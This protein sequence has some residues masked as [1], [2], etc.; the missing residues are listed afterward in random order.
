[1]RF[2]VWPQDIVARMKDFHTCR[3]CSVKL[4][5]DCDNASPRLWSVLRWWWAPAQSW[6]V[7]GWLL[8]VRKLRAGRSSS[9]ELVAG[10]DGQTDAI[11]TVGTALLL[12][13]EGAHSHLRGARVRPIQRPEPGGQLKWRLVP[14]WRRHFKNH[15]LLLNIGLCLCLQQLFWAYCMSLV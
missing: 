11:P 10:T 9:V 14:A 7:V 3:K 6:S 15:K 12:L 4:F 5:A 1:M 8:V 2:V 13:L